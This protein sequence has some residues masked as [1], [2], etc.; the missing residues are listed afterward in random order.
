MAQLIELFQKSKSTI[1]EH[2]KN[3]YE[4]GELERATTVRNFRTVQTEEQH[5]IA[6]YE[7]YKQQLPQPMDELDKYLKIQ[8]IA[9]EKKVNKI[10]F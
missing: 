2:I 6:E 1:S 7:K 10:K 4:E 9:P 3:I 8:A 5:A